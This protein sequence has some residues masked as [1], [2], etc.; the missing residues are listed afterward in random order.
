MIAKD[1]AKDLYR[2]VR[3]ERLP[4]ERFR[5]ANPQAVV[6]SKVVFGGDHTRAA[7]GP[8]VFIAPYTAIWVTDGGGLTGARLEVGANTYIGEF[9]NIRC[10]GTPIVIGRD[11]LISQHITIVGSNHGHAKGT[12]INEQPWIGDGITIGD[13]VWVGAGAVIAAGVTIGNGAVVGAN[14]VVLS[15]V[16]PDAIVVGAPAK[17]VGVRS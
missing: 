17:Q 12:L 7:L 1:I 8:G 6:S 14:S 2:L 4:L 16:A 10:A 13:D 3:D 15:D 5:K 11:C 9:N